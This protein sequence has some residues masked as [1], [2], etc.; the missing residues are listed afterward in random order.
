M[1]AWQEG[2]TIET[3]QL[4]P[5]TIVDVAREAGVSFKTV[6][7][8]L[9]GEPNVRP[10]T[11]QR[12]MAA[13]NEL[14]YTANPYARSLRASRSRLIG[15]LFSNPSRNYLGEIQIGA[16]QKASAE[17]F[18]VTFEQLSGPEA[19]DALP[20]G[21]GPL[22]GVV[23]V[24]PLTEDRHL[25]DFLM[26]MQTP[27]VRLS[28]TTAHGE[29]GHVSMDDTA[30]ARDM[31]DYLVSLGHRRI[32]FICGPPD[33]PQAL[34]RE[35]G[36]RQSLEAHGIDP[37]QG[38]IVPG[39]FDFESGLQAAATLLRLTPRPTAIFASNDDMAAAVLAMAYRSR[40][41]IPEDLSVAGFD[42]T[43]LAS[44]ISPALTTV[45]QPGREMAATAIGMLLDKSA[46]V[47]LQ[48]VELPYRLVIRDTTG[49][50]S[51]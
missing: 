11:R 17:G 39:G 23:L 50:L 10:Q 27:F 14:G 43:P 7:R 5:A 30:A 45:Y 12:V 4:R 1:R 6:S 33:H 20:R 21:S 19:Q 40:I 31:T 9:N 49:P 34:L 42:D 16:L 48:S 46:P 51:P 24:P 3:R 28:H 41:A 26:E 25:M 2:L 37:G 29:T 13:I 22:A 47:P 38:L 8:V 36:F 18:S 35:A 44:T 32:G 15:V